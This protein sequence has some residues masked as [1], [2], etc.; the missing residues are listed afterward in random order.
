[1]EI[2]GD[3]PS[4]I[5][6]RRRH[7]R[8]ANNKDRGFLFQGSRHIV[9]R[10]RLDSDRQVPT[11]FVDHLKQFLRPFG[12]GLVLKSTR[13]DITSTFHD[14]GDGGDESALVW[15]VFLEFA[16]ENG[17]LKDDIDGKTDAFFEGR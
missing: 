11:T 9:L 14:V 4:C 8:D 13:Q 7:L 6:R 3:A 16:P 1:M 15:V 5:S 17:R 2:H 10:L 12:I